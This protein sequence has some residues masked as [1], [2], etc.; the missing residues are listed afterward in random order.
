MWDQGINNLNATFN[1][2]FRPGV[3]ESQLALALA[4]WEA[5]AN[6]NIS[7]VG[8]TA[9]PMNTPGLT[10]GDHRFGDIRVGGYTFSDNTILAL[11]YAPPPGDTESGDIE[12][13]TSMNFNIGATY[14]L[15]SVL[16]HEAGHALGLGEAPNPAE[17]MYTNYHG[18]L[19]GL[20]PGDTAG[21]Q[22]IYGPRTLDSY[23]QNGQGVS[24]AS[25]VDLTSGLS[26][27][28]LEVLG[29]LSLATIGD[30]EYFKVTAPAG[31]TGSLQ[32]TAAAY[33]V[34]LLSP[35]ISLYDS[36]GNLLSS[37]SKAASWC[38][39]MTVGTSGVTAGQTY[40]IAVTGATKNAF[41][42]GAYNL[43]VSFGVQA[44]PPSPASTPAPP[45]TTKVDR[46][47][48]I[49]QVVVPDQSLTTYNDYDFFVFQVAQSGVY[50]V[51]AI[52]T[53]IRVL[54]ASRNVVAWGSNTLWFQ[55][56]RAGSLYIVL[57]SAPTQA[58]VPSYWLGIVW[59]PSVS[60]ARGTTAAS[61]M[62]ATP[63]AATRS[64]QTA[65]ASSAQSIAS[66][67]PMIR[68]HLVTQVVRPPGARDVSAGG[69]F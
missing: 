53:N 37:A 29:G 21:I 67:P 59:L 54:D 1:S 15:Y 65:H 51:A 69:R 30:T 62:V 52:G 11:T 6:I 35:K 39:N 49:S 58:P 13:N 61:P 19:T 24:L 17:V 40:Y 38:D 46:M 68:R 63:Q 26:S 64:V 43:K 33:D 3:W 7:Q 9:L 18:V 41:A 66:Q 4:T 55:A 44:T 8:D 60:T 5:A 2:K 28:G 27:T 20:A 16:L 12:V 31:A 57:T 34:S 32:V 36:S 56:G 50:Q 42:V 23:Q 48:M 45:V 47:G 22:A 10:Q 25:A 14:D